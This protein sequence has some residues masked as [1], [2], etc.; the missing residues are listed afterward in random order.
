[1]A[2]SVTNHVELRPV[3][4]PEAVGPGEVLVD[5]PPTTRPGVVVIEHDPATAHE[6]WRDSGEASHRRVVPVAIKVSQG[7][8]LVEPERVLEQAANELDVVLV[9]GQT[10]TCEGLSHLLIEVV[11]VTVVGLAARA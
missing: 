1:M 8:R 11:A 9:D 7:D 6:E 10:V 3:L 4:E 5:C 2:P